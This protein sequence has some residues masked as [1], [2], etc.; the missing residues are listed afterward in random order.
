MTIPVAKVPGIAS[1]FMGSIKV[2]RIE[3]LYKS[4]NHGIK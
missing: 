2:R 4:A 1:A 3:V